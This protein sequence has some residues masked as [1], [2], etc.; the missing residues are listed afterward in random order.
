MKKIIGILLCLLM[1]SSC[2]TKSSFDGKD[3]PSTAG[4]LHVAGGQLCSN[5]GKP[6]MLRGISG[7]G[8][9]ASERFTTDETYHEI[10]HFIGANV[11]RQAMYT[12][13]MGSAGYCTGGNK[14]KLKELMLKG[15]EYGEKNDMY[16][17]LDWHIL[18]DGDPNKY[19]NQA[20]DFFDE[21]SK[22]CKDK[23]NVIYEICNEPNKVEWSSIK[24]YARTII[25]IIRSNDPDS[26]IIVGTPNWSQDVDVVADDPLEYDDLL[27]AFHFYSAT[28]KQ[29]MRNKL[30]K[31]IDKGLPVIVSEYGVC[32]SNGDQPYDLEEADVW[33]D[34]L[35]E[36][37]ISHVMWNFSKVP[38][39]SSAIRNDCLK[40]K[41][42]TY[43]D[44]STS[45]QWLIDMIKERSA[46]EK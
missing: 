4:N 7:N 36:N 29:D 11:F 18:S 10:A 22:A 16:I 33:I 31:A 13:G 32:A 1:L 34:M 14:E 27:Y 19:I 9:A 41:D 6:V 15:V 37:K 20:K 23:N 38:E 43:E 25:E 2:T 44:F 26:L 21:M 8:I 24:E 39:A 28:H 17:I 45:G 3:R 30:Q 40:A 46:K 5:D 42:F 35:E 12:Y